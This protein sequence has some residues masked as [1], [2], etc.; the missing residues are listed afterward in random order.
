M[1]TDK[2][3]PGLSI[4]CVI[5]GFH[6]NELRVL[7]LKMKNMDKWA[8]PGGFVRSNKDVDE[9]AKQTLKARTGLRNIFLHQFH[10][11]G[12]KNRA[13]KNH[14]SSLVKKNVISP[15]LQSWFDQRFITVGYYALVEYSKV[16]KPRPDHISD[17]IEWCPTTTLPDLI[18]D[19]RD[20]ILKAHET[21]RKELNF[22]P[23][24]LNLLPDEFTMPELQIA[25]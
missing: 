18:L 3:I 6:E 12:K 22:Q 4:D 24:G 25:L 1:Q 16:K 2:F 15:T 17:T 23:I 19:H 7:L 11:F 9:E 13:R 14:A 21:L 10:L 20:I 8:L 5:F